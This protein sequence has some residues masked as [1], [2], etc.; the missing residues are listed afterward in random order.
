[1]ISCQKA[2]HST[3]KI[4]KIMNKH[5]FNTA[6]KYT[7]LKELRGKIN[8]PPKSVG[9]FNTPFSILDRTMEED[10]KG[11]REL[12]LH[13]KLISPNKH[14]ENIPVNSRTHILLKCT[15]NT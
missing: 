9:D 10:Q 7:K 11:K 1:M 12:E 8:S 15:R 5:T 6:P 14:I 13:S 2:H 3:Q 4:K